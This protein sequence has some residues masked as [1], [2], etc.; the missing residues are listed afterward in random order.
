VGEEVACSIFVSVL[1]IFLRVGAEDYDS[2]EGST[3]ESGSD[4]DAED[5]FKGEKADTDSQAS[6]TEPPPLLR[7]IE[8]KKGF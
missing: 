2:E 6:S 5:T 4:S 8:D 7:D 3:E 1:I